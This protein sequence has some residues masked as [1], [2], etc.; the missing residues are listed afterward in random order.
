MIGASASLTGG[1]TARPNI[2]RRILHD[3]SSTHSSD[4]CD[5]EF[6]DCDDDSQC[7]SCLEIDQSTRCEVRDADIHPEHC[8]KVWGVVCCIFKDDATKGMGCANN[9]KL[10]RVI[11]TCFS[12]GHLERVAGLCEFVVDVGGALPNL[13]GSNSSVWSPTKYFL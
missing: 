4:V 11:G 6:K 3:A 8:N 13:S 2:L 1:A 12:L 7:S 5:V 10:D 9:D